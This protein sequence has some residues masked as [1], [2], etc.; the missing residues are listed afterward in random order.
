MNDKE[1]LQVLH[2]LEGYISKSVESNLSNVLRT[3]TATI[4]SKDDEKRTA[5][6]KFPFD[7][8]SITIPNK[9]SD[10]I[11]KDDEV[12]VGYWGT[13]ANAFVMMKKI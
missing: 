12:I 13:L 8:T 7:K 5:T 1:A 10:E 6:V 3:K 4:I 2:L 9:T 11:A